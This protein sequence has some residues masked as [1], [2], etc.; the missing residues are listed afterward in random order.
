MG[1]MPKFVVS[2]SVAHRSAFPSFPSTRHEN[3]FLLPLPRDT[4]RTA[5]PTRPTLAIS[6]RQNRFA[7]PIERSPTRPFGHGTHRRGIATRSTRF[8]TA[9]ARRFAPQSA[10]STST[11]GRMA[12]REGGTPTGTRTP[13]RGIPS[14]SRTLG[15]R[16]SRTRRTT[17]RA[18]GALRQHTPFTPTKAHTRRAPRRQSCRHGRFPTHPRRRR[19][20]CPRH[21]RL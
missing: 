6:R 16:K 4:H 18:G 10:S 17:C 13:R 15:R 14:Q 19:S 1:K 5:R 2:T 21:H 3:A 12:T 8:R 20:V 9:S 7:A 11:V